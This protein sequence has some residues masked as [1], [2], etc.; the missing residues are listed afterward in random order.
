MPN[1]LLISLFVGTLISA[2]AMY[3]AFRNV[4][5]TELLAYLMSIQYVWVIPSSA[6]V[7][8]GFA[9][10]ALRWQYIMGAS[11]RI[12]FWQ[13]F[14][15]VM[16]GFA[17]NCVL[18]GRIGELARPL[19]LKKQVEVPLTTGLAT[20]VVER[21]FDLAMLLLLF[22]MVTAG[23]QIDPQVQI[24]FGQVVLNRE[25]LRAVFNG[26]AA[27]SAVLI[28]A[29]VLLGLPRTRSGL[30]QLV[31]SFPRCLA[32]FGAEVKQKLLERVCRPVVR[33]IDNVGLGMALIKKPRRMSACLFLSMCIW[34]V[35]ALSYYLF[36]LGC[37]DI[38][39]SLAQIS[40]MMVIICLVIALPSAPGFWG[41]W[42]AGGVFALML[43]GVS[44]KDGAGFTLANHAVQMF[45]VI[46]VGLAS[47]WISG[48]NI[49]QVSFN[50][51]Q[52]VRP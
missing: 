4:P 50:R 11:H 52:P 7:I 19:V 20:I 33:I 45:P 14:H 42:E 12:D 48:V 8:L 9:L 18:P 29:M 32:P 21:V 44:E 36:S 28:A 22:V 17:T 31:L 10:R 51:A 46:V 16:I 23:M 47:A 40:A 13:A 34:A 3:L 6:L 2:A 41:L 30:N 5:F 25:T 37:P 15:P 24:R 49:V 26:M 35:A 27:A 1:R 39:L 43:F 38:E